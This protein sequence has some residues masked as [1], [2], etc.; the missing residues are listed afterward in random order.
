MNSKLT[1]W[2]ILIIRI[3]IGAMFAMHGY[4][5]ITGGIEDWTGLGEAMGNLGIHFLPAFWGF[6]AS[7]SEFGG[8]ILFALGIF[9]RPAA[10]LLF[11]TMF[12]AAYAHISGGDGI[13]QASH[14]IEAGSVFL[15]LL[16]TG[17]G[18]FALAKL[19]HK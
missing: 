8:G 1:D 12:V 5:K 18:K 7:V 9:F 3:G 10:F 11:F 17:P 19:I 13:S 16:L 15:G 4:P 14:A 2:S 6:C